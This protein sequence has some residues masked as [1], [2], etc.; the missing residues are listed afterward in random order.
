MVAHMDTGMTDGCMHT[1]ICRY[2]NA[3]AYGY[4]DDRWMHAQVNG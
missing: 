3:F 2:F 4:A 1:W